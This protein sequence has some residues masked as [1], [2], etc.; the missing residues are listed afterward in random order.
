MRQNRWINYYLENEN[1]KFVDL[2]NKEEEETK[3]PRYTIQKDRCNECNIE[4][5]KNLKMGKCPEIPKL[6]PRLVKVYEKYMQEK[7]EKRNRKA[8]GKN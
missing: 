4:D 2:I 1:L 8:K 6:V 3:I 7:E 5:I